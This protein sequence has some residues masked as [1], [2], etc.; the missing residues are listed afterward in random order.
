MA[1]HNL[2]KAGLFVIQMFRVLLLISLLFKIFLVWLLSKS[3]NIGQDIRC[4]L[5]WCIHDK[6]V[7]RYLRHTCYTIN[8]RPC[9]NIT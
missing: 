9:S 5:C 2:V 8:N 6:N 7:S 4:G 3:N 1:K